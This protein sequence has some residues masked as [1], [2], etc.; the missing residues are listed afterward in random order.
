MMKALQKLLNIIYYD[1]I[2]CV[3]LYKI[4]KGQLFG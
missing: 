4:I 3:F 2:A 1:F